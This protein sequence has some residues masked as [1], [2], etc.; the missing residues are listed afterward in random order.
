MNLLIIGNSV[1]DYI[2]KDG[3][4]TTQPGGIFYSVTTLN[5][6]KEEGDRISLITAADKDHYFL[7]EDEYEKLDGKLFNSVEKVPK[8]H[9]NTEGN[10]ERHERYE[11]I[12]QPL[13]FKTTNLNSFDG[14]YINMVTGFDITLNQLREIR[15]NF[16]GL[17]YF[18]VHTFSRG[19]DDNMDRNFRTIPNF[20]DW[21]SNLDIIQVN[22]SELYTLN[23]N[24]TEE[25]I[26]REVLNC[27][28]KF[29]IL[30]LEDKGAKMFFKD[31]SLIKLIYEPAINVNVKNKVGCGDVFGSV[32]FYNYVK[33]NSITDAL[34][35][36]NKAAGLTASYENIN[37]IKNLKNDIRI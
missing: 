7:F 26:I 14:I 33:S 2:Q 11:N 3:G 22:K 19:L 5:S 29:L 35:L 9:L 30:T 27:G 31:D 37:E 21:V 10:N 20:N 6:L 23:E 36:A 13:D 18:D 17:I 16:A 4:I 12:N 15:K 32:F 8:V 1:V 28:V 24:K 25:E 34:K